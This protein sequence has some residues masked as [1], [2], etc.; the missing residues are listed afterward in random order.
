MSLVGYVVPRPESELTVDEIRTFL[1]EKLP[2]HMV[3]TAFVFLDSCL[4]RRRASWIVV[5]FPKPD[6]RLVRGTLRGGA[7]AG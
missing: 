2:D 6:H 5:R 1:K 7:N 3:P 4:S